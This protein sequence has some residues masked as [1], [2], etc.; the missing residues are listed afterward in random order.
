MFQHKISSGSECLDVPGVDGGNCVY[1]ANFNMFGVQ[2]LFLFLGVSLF[3][4]FDL[5]FLFCVR[6]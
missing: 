3:Y 2:F 6:D 4:G 5:G 1:E